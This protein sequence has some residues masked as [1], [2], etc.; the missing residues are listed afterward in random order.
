MRLNKYFS[1]LKIQKHSIKK[2]FKQ[3]RLKNIF[4]D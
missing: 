4:N 2:T 1:G 3:L